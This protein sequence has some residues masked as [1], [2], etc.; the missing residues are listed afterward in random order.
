VIGVA[1]PVTAATPPA[2]LRRGRW[3]APVFERESALPL[4]VALLLRYGRS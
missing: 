1:L 4:G 2:E 3:R